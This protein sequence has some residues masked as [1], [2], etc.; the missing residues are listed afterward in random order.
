MNRLAPIIITLALVAA[1]SAC[2]NPAANVSQAVTSEASAQPAPLAAGAAGEKLPITGENSRI[3]FVG[4]KVT[5]SEGGRFE[6]FS[7]TVYLVEADPARSRVEIAIDMNSVGTDADNLAEHLK[8]ADFFDVPKFP[9]AT[10]VSTEIKPGGD[11]GAT[12]TVTGNLGL[13]GVT[14]A[15]TFP[16]T[17]KVDATAAAL[18]AEFYINR[19]DFGIKYE[20]RT[21]DLIRD[22]V[23]IRLKV[24]APRRS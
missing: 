17:I 21:N 7:G 24:R 23:V 3:E 15:I 16:A 13:H 4:S 5:G 11:K 2:A 19:N 1:S 9:E 8:T 22:E 10:F 6:K 12:H 18:D 20:G 14:K